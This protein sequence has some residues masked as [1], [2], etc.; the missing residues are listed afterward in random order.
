MTAHVL[1]PYMKRD[2]SMHETGCFYTRN[3]LFPYMKRNVSILPTKNFVLFH[4]PQI[5]C[6]TGCYH[7]ALARLPAVRSGSGLEWALDEES[8]KFR[9]ITC[10]YPFFYVQMD[11]CVTL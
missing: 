11:Y 5:A 2:V 6:S 8:V 1:F 7:G 10:F 4:K 9:C 3:G